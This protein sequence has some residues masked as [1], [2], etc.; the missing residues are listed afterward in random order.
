MNNVLL[1]YKWLK[2][3]GSSPCRYKLRDRLASD[4]A[5]QHAKPSMTA[6]NRDIL[7]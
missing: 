1:W 2:N 6:C 7:P 3:L 5:K 4:G